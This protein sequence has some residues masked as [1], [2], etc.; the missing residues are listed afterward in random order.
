MPIPVINYAALQPQGSPAFKNL[1]PSIQQ[2]M[3]LAFAPKM[4]N[5][6]LMKNQLANALAR[7]NVQYA[8]EEKE[9]NIGNTRAQTNLMGAQAQLI[10]SEMLLNTSKANA[11]PIENLLNIAKAMNQGNRFDD[12]FNLRAFI[13]TMDP[14]TR[15]AFVANHAKEMNAIGEGLVNGVSGG[16]QG[17][18]AMP[19]NQLLN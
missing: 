11:I 14:S 16:G 8:P 19:G 5:E 10:P 4:M 15:A 17:G 7:I 1:M 6:E 3:S 2:G 12:A 13:A 18:Q 9:A